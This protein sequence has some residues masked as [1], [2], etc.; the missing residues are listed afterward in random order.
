MQPLR[1]FAEQKS[2]GRSRSVIFNTNSIQSSEVRTEAV[3]TI[4]SVRPSQREGQSSAE[5]DKC[6]VS[7]K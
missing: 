1:H 7:A 3:N 2:K 5:S 4:F 6:P